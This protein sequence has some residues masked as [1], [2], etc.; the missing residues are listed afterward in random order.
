MGDMFWEEF[1]AED[2]ARFLYKL[3]NI[4][5]ENRLG[6]GT[7]M[8]GIA[9]ALWNYHSDGVAEDVLNMLLELCDWIKLKRN[10]G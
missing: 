1:D 2:Q 6:A 7:Q 8:E 3:S 4:F 5:Q 9:E 10:E